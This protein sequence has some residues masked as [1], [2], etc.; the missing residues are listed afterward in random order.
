MGRPSYP[1]RI[2]MAAPMYRMELNY[3]P[4][5]PHQ[6]ERLLRQPSVQENSAIANYLDPILWPQNKPQ[7][8]ASL[9]SDILEQIWSLPNQLLI[10][11]ADIKE[12]FARTSRDELGYAEWLVEISL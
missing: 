2:G 4:I 9:L 10:P 12:R 6:P 11:P 7:P 8:K 5:Q 3:Q 1:L